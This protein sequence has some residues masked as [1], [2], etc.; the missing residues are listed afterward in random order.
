MHDNDH[1]NEVLLGI[2]IDFIH[3]N[4]LMK[5]VWCIKFAIN[6]HG[7][8]NI[9]SCILETASLLFSFFAPM[10]DRQLGL[11]LEDCVW[12]LGALI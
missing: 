8:K 2:R 4:C 11:K 10:S 5:N 7:W 1:L 3:G 6:V 9:Q 12:F